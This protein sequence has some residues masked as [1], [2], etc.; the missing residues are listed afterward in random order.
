MADEVTTAL[1]AMQDA[2]N[3]DLASLHEILRET[4]AETNTKLL[5]IQVRLDQL[6]ASHNAV[7][8]NVQWLTANTQGVF[9]ML[10]SPDMIGQMMGMLGGGLSGGFPGQPKPDAG[11]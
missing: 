3:E 11:T 5:A 2:I 1:A 6:V 9:Q 4:L 10:N 8:E 7:G